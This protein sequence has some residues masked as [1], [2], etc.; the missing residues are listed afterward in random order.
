MS[1]LRLVRAVIDSVRLVDGTKDFVMRG[2]ADG[3]LVTAAI[4]GFLEARSTCA[5]LIEKLLT[6]D[7]TE[8]KGVILPRVRLLLGTYGRKNGL[9]VRVGTGVVRAVRGIGLSWFLTLRL[10]VCGVVVGRTFG[11]PCFVEGQSGT[12]CH[13]GIP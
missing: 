13:L 5:L 8:I 12:L 10:A 9:R 4:L 1:Y 11:A 7:Q 6:R 3:R 2:L